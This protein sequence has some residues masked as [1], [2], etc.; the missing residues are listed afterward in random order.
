M[1]DLKEEVIISLNREAVFEFASNLKNSTE[2]LANVVEVNKLSE[3]PVGA[4]TKFEEIRQFRN[5]RV[6]AVLEVVTYNPPHSYSVKSENKGLVVTYTYSF[7]EE[8]ENQ[9]RV[10]FEGE[11]EAVSFPMKLMRPMMVKMLKKEDGDHLVSLKNTIEKQAD[12]PHGES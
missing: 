12:S 11:V 9:T 2:V 1:P 6:G 7:T 3:G 4:G 8:K 10:R 5:R